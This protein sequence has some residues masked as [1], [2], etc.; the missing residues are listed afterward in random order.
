MKSAKKMKIG[1]KDGDKGKE[2]DAVEE[3]DIGC[4]NV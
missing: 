4:E 3:G 2:D 1:F